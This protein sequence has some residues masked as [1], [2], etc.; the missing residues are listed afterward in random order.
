LVVALA[1]GLSATAFAATALG[2]AFALI[3]A[4][5]VGKPF[6]YTQDRVDPAVVIDAAFCIVP[7][8]ARFP[9]A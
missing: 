8:F 3:F 5:F 2:G 6:C 9:N 1:E 7:L 4:A